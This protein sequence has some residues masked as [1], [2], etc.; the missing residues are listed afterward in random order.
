[1]AYPC[2]VNNEARPVLRTPAGFSPQPEIGVQIMDAANCNGCD[3]TLNN[4][5]TIF[6]LT[7]ITESA[8]DWISE[9]LPS[10]A[11]TFGRATVIE[12]RFIGD[13][14]DGILGDGLTV[15]AA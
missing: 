9:S 13:I 4:Q 8:S 14:I 7:P 15:E 1:V 11:M 12:H 10:D 3:F 5:G 2:S 6:L